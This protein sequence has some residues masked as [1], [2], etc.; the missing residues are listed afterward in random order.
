M[1][2]I[3]TLFMIMIFNLNCEDNKT[4]SEQPKPWILSQGFDPKFEYPN[5][6]LDYS[7]YEP[8]KKLKLV[9]KADEDDWLILFPANKSIY[10][11]VDDDNNLWVEEINVKKDSLKDKD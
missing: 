7:I 11:F 3:L 10:I 2:I 6:Q 5:T 1:S 8:P 9:D 4:E